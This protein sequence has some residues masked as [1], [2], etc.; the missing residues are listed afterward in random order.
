MQNLDFGQTTQ[1]QKDKQ[2][3]R[4]EALQRQKTGGNPFGVARP[5][6]NALSKMADKATLGQPVDMVEAERL[7]KAAIDRKLIDDGLRKKA[8]EE[9]INPPEPQQP[10]APAQGG[11]FFQPRKRP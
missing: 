9:A 7:Q 5:E 8:I 10:Q 3:A 1:A 2:K 6:E 4:S 11:Q